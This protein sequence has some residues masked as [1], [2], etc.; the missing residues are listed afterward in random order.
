LP[1]GRYTLDFIYLTSYNFLDKGWSL[2]GVLRLDYAQTQTGFMLRMS[3]EPDYIPRKKDLSRIPDFDALWAVNR[4]NA[5]NLENCI[6][7]A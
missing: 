7:G 4:S 2:D 3:A 6:M 1:Q 5:S